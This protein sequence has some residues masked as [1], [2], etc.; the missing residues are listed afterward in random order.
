M[1][2][3]IVESSSKKRVLYEDLFNMLADE[4]VECAATCSCP[5]FGDGLS[6]GLPMLQDDKL[7]R[8]SRKG[9]G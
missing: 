6:I 2:E 3:V 8:S 1:P 7:A 4:S 9:E 5:T